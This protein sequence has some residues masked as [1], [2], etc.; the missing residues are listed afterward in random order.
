MSANGSYFLYNG[1]YI[2]SPNTGPSPTGL[3]IVA[4]NNSA[5][6]DPSGTN[7]MLTKTL[8]TVRG[9]VTGDPAL[10]RNSLM[11]PRG[12]LKFVFGAGP[13]SEADIPSGDNSYGPLP[14]ECDIVM[15]GGTGPLCLVTFTISYQMFTACSQSSSVLQFNYS[16]IFSMDEHFL[17][18]LTTSGSFTTKPTTNPDSL[19]GLAWFPIPTGFRRKAPQFTISPDGLTL[20]FVITDEEMPAA[21]L[22]NPIVSASAHFA[23]SMDNYKWYNSFSASAKTHKL[24]TKLQVFSQLLAMANSRMNFNQEIIVGGVVGEDLY[25]QECSLS[26]TT[27]VIALTS[28]PNGI[29]PA[30][31]KLFTGV[32]TSNNQVALGPYGSALLQAATTLWYSP[33]IGNYAP[34][35]AGS[36]GINISG[37]I[38]TVGT[39]SNTPSGGGP[40]TGQNP[41]SPYLAY[42]DTYEWAVDTGVV[43]VP[44]AMLGGG[45]SVYQAHDPYVVV[46]HKGHAAM[47]KKQPTFPTAR[48]ESGSYMTRRVQTILSPELAPDNSTVEFGIM[49]DYE[50]VIP[51]KGAAASGSG[52]AFED[53]SYGTIAAPTNPM[54]LAKTTPYAQPPNSGIVASGGGKTS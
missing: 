23:T 16:R 29:Y 4:F 27:M 14:Q 33:C 34:P 17:T 30:S 54:I 15:L 39:A 47:A 40:S 43:I 3:D 45:Q 9:L 38:V 50:L 12:A 37:A 35:V 44:S 46:T 1:V 8:L 26:L 22:P 42:K 52:G 5:V 21:N 2:G 18:T 25:G 36:S 10:I 32:P 7:L 11:V 28:G 48:L 53:A 49:W 51:M 31:T 19:R 24:A 20:A 13:F 41:K 6:Y